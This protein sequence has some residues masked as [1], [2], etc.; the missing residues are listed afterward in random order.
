[1]STKAIRRLMEK[2]KAACE[3]DQ[4]GMS[5]AEVITHREAMAEVVAIEKAARWC[6]GEDNGITP[7]DVGDLMERI[8]KESK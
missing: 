6:D 3:T 2:Y 4:H 5:V 8:A 1:M 7:N